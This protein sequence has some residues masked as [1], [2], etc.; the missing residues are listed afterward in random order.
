MEKHSLCMEGISSSM[1]QQNK[2]KVA[3]MIGKA[4]LIGKIGK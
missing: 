4:E 3:E 1:C 2:Y